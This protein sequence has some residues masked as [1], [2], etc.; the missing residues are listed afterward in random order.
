M[1]RRRC[2][3]VVQPARAGQTMQ[4]PSGNE[5]LA[6]TTKSQPPGAAPGLGHPDPL[7]SASTAAWQAGDPFAGTTHLLASIL[8]AADSPAAQLLSTLG[9]DPNAIAA[10]TS[11]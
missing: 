1:T 6:G 10:E 5:G 11:R 8:R 3:E 2:C 4:A 9:A 7:R